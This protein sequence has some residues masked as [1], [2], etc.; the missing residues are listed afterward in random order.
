MVATVGCLA[1]LPSNRAIARLPLP[2]TFLF[3]A[4]TLFPLPSTLTNRIPRSLV[5][6]TPC[7]NLIT[8]DKYLIFLSQKHLRGNEVSEKRMIEYQL[9]NKAGSDITIRRYEPTLQSDVETRMLNGTLPG[10]MIL[11]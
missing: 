7:H 1:I 4:P 3:L 9:S 10:I 6:P 8:D 11:N 2:C 5:L